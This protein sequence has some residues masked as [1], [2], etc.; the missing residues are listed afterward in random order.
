MAINPEAIELRVEGRVQGVGFRWHTQRAALGLGLVGWVK[1]MPDGSV[2]ALAK[3]ESEQLAKFR[4]AVRRGPA[5]ARVD[6]IEER[7]ASPGSL[8]GC[9]SFEVAY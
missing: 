9:L 8:D 2:L 7:P 4:E 3:G 1:N 6:R 5:F